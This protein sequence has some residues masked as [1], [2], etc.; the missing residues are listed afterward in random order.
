MAIPFSA[1]R[2]S[3]LLILY[4]Y[5]LTSDHEGFWFGIPAIQEALPPT[6]SGAFTQRALDALISE[7]MVEQGGSDILKKDL[8]ALTEHGIKAAED[9]L[10]SR[11][12]K[13]EEYEPA[14]ESDQILSRIHHPEDH[15]ALSEGFKQL[16]SEIEKSNSFNEELEGNGDLVESEIDAASTLASAERVRV[17]RLKGLVLPTLRYLAKKFADQ[18]IGELAKKLIALLTGWAH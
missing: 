2:E 3:V 1:L 12:L 17:S 8:Y 6:T 11:G 13:I 18:S 16:R 14:P 15:A 5:M 10:T 4:D 9:L 7:K